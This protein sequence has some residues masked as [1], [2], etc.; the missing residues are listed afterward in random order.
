MCLSQCLC[1]LKKKGGGYIGIGELAQQFRALIVLAGDLGL[2]PSTCMKVHHS[3]SREFNAL[4]C[5]HQPCKWCRDIHAGERIIHINKSQKLKTLD[6]FY[7]Y[8]RFAS[9]YVC[10]MWNNPCTL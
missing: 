2:I 7:V 1:S 3:S 6:V 4:F 8:E 10:V 5:R 9:M